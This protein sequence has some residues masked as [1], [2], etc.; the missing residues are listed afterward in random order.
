MTLLDFLPFPS[1]YITTLGKAC[2]VL[3]PTSGSF[4]HTKPH[5]LPVPHPVSTSHL[6]RPFFSLQLIV[7]KSVGKGTK[8]QYSG[9]CSRSTGWRNIMAS[10]SSAAWSSPLR[11]RATSPFASHTSTSPSCCWVSSSWS[12]LETEQKPQGQV[13]S[14]QIRNKKKSSKFFLN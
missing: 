7:F 12:L 13:E 6:Y 2:P 5:P 9:T 3:P 10:S 14:H 8:V 1:P 4:L 11:I